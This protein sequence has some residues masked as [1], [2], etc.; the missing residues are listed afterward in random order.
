M[1]KP[2]PLPADIRLIVELCYQPFR[3]GPEIERLLA[4]ARGLLS[5]FH[6]K[7]DPAV[8][9]DAKAGDTLRLRVA[10]RLN[11]VNERGERTLQVRAI[12]SSVRFARPAAFVSPELLMELEHYRDGYLVASLGASS[13]QALDAL[14]VGYARA[15]VY[16]RDIDSVAPLERFRAAS[17]D[18]NA[19]LG[20]VS[21]EVVRG[22]DPLAQLLQP[23][24]MRQRAAEFGLAQQQALQQRVRAKLEVRQH[25]QLFQRGQIK[26][27]AFVHHQQAAAPGACF[28]V[29]EALDGAKGRRL[30]MPFDIQAKAARHH[31]DNLVLV[32]FAGHDLRHGHLRRIDARRKAR[33]FQHDTGGQDAQSGG[34]L[35][36]E[37]GRRTRT[38]PR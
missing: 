12:V 6:A 10:R 25:P 34:A 23:R 7:F 14:N 9:G 4:V 17:M 21:F 2:M 26:V 22:D 32:Q 11:E 37:A 16:A 29:Q 35:R 1:N 19:L 30:V 28:F 38:S 31:V 13:G 33:G 8:G 24:M 18:Y 36:R 3:C 27:L 20:D 5:L 15:R